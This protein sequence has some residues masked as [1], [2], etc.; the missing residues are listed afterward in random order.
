MPLPVLFHI[1][2]L[3]LVII[4]L[5]FKRLFPFPPPPLEL[6]F[7]LE[8][9]FPLNYFPP[10]NTISRSIFSIR[11][12]WDWPKYATKPKFIWVR[13]VPDTRVQAPT[14]PMSMQ[15]HIEGEI[16]H[17]SLDASPIHVHFV[18]AVSW[19]TRMF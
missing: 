15:M 7:P 2:Q 10:L 16:S 6:C 18:A 8:L 12:H 1:H 13:T 17:P 9:F 19:T 14:L 11:A 4:F 3:L 5:Y